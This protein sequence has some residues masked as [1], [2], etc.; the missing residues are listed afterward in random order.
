M[1]LIHSKEFLLARR[2][3]YAS[4][5]AP[6]WEHNCT[7]HNAVCIADSSIAANGSCTAMTVAILS[8]KMTCTVDAFRKTFSCILSRLDLQSGRE[9]ETTSIE[10]MCTAMARHKP[11]DSYSSKICDL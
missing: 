4:T 11:K 8:Q 3:E 10:N 1:L 7:R 5:I 9:V 6:D 2:G